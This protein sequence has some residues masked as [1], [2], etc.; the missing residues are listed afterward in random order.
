[1]QAKLFRPKMCY[2]SY[3]HN[4]VNACLRKV[5]ICANVAAQLQLTVN[6]NIETTIFWPYLYLEDLKNIYS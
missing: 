1:M 4:A 6:S 2:A 5:C 3:C